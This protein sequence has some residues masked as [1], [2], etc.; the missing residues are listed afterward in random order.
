MECHSRTLVKMLTYRALS[1]AV[2]VAFTV[3]VMKMSAE[4]AISFS[5]GLHAILMVNYYV[6]ERAWMRVSWKNP[7]K[8]I[9]H[10][11]KTA[12]NKLSVCLVPAR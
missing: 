8:A 4:H 6:H 2:T 9:K 12:R 5:L 11:A 7:S 10:V 1:I 3:F